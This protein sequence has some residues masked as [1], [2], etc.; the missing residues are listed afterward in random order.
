M[1]SESEEKSPRAYTKRCIPPLQGTLPPLPCTDSFANCRSSNRGDINTLNKTC[2]KGL[3]NDLSAR[4]NQRRKD[5]KVTWTLDKYHRG[6]STYFTGVRILSDR[7]TALPEVDGAGLRQVVVRIT[8]RQ[9]K[10]RTK[11]PSTKG[12]P[13]ESENMPTTTQ[14]CTEHI[15][16]QRMR[17]AGREEP[18]RI[19]GHTTPTTVEDLDHPLFAPGLSMIERLEAFKNLGSR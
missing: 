11:Q 16:L 8:S 6:P 3:A 14:D 13:A 7:A 4:I 5:E 2:C 19:W 12:S 17:W 9:S 1:A 10:G 18:W 15:V